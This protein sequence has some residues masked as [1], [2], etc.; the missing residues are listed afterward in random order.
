MGDGFLASL[1]TFFFIKIKLAVWAI[2]YLTGILFLDFVIGMFEVSICIVKIICWMPYWTMFQWFNFFYVIA[3]TWAI[4]LFSD[5]CKNW[6]IKWY[7]NRDRLLYIKF[8]NNVKRIK[9][10]KSLSKRLNFGLKSN[11]RW[12]SK[13]NRL[14]YKNS[15]KN[16]YK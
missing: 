10:K 2:Y 3:L 5:K 8:I 11:R 4:L 13:S 15:I 14:M 12:T 9:K 16:K 7:E 1:L 6:N